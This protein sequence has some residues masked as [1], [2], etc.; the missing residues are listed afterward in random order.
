M[1]IHVL[2]HSLKNIAER[3][4]LS[5]LDLP[6]FIKE[7]GFEGMEVSDRQLAGRDE[8]WLN[9][10]R[11]ECRDH[12]C[13]LIVDINVD[14]TTADTVMLTEEIEH[15]KSIL[16]IAASLKTHHVRI[17]IGGQRFTVQKFFRKKRGTAAPA[18]EKIT[19]PKSGKIQI[20]KLLMLFGHIVRKSMSARVSDVQGKLKRAVHSLQE[21]MPTASEHG[22]RIGIENHWG[23]SGDPQN[24][25]SIINR[26]GSANLGTCPDMGNFPRG[27][28]P[29]AS[30]K[31]LAPFTVI[32]HAKSYSFR[33]DGEEKNIHYQKILTLFHES[34]FNGPITVEYE[35]MADD[36]QG[37]CLT[38]ELILRH[39]K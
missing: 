11:N 29:L 33:K 22:I 24:I 27:I 14:F 21:I 28:D 31:M 5:L 39:W 30:L 17:C 16:R 35:G 19:H 8:E 6:R 12:H 25:I 9:R 23:L 32:L 13:E 7:L 34:G 37:C 3:N 26:V 20:E 1:K 18:E 2:A 38:R 15:A 10:L 36:L 4:G